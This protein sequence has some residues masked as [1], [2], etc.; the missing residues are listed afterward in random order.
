MILEMK[1]RKIMAITLHTTISRAVSQF[2]S[3]FLMSKPLEKSA[4]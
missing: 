1:I 2:H 4:A 3:H